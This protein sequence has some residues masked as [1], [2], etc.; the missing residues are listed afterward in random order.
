[1]VYFYVKNNFDKSL[2]DIFLLFE[3]EVKTYV[4]GLIANIKTLSM[5]TK[6]NAFTL[7]KKN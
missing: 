6:I 2:S 4:H 7:S 5:V 1:M 3:T